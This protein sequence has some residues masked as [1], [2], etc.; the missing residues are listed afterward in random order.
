MGGV[1]YQGPSAHPRVWFTAANREGAGP[2]TVTFNNTTPPA[3]TSWLWRFGDGTTATSASPA[4]VYNTKGRYSVTLLGYG[5]G[6]A[7]SLTVRFYV[8]VTAT[9]TGIG[10]AARPGGFQPH[11]SVLPNPF[12]RT[13]V[14]HVQGAEPHSISIFDHIGRPV[15]SMV[16]CNTWN[17]RDDAGQRQ[18]RGVYLYT[19]AGDGFAVSGKMMKTR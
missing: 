2:L 6:F 11:V 19:I 15:R 13:A 8:V 12:E 18:G 10:D 7:D 14:F 3:Y 1:E 5:A 16:N 4:H 17:G 9:S